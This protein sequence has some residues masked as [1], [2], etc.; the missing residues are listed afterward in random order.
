MHLQTKMTYTYSKMEEEGYVY[1]MS[2]ECMPGLFKIGMT[3]DDPETR[4]KELSSATGVPFPFRVEITKKVARPREKEHALHELLGVLG[5][6][7]NDKREF[8]NCGR[9]VI[10]HLFGLIDGTDVVVSNIQ[11]SAVVR[12]YAINVVK[13]DESKPENSV[14]LEKTQ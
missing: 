10:E 4:A 6:R 7:V 13:L 14:I 5:F 1:C 3:L 8:F 9:V 12:N 2:N 11:T